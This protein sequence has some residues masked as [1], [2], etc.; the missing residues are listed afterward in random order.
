MFLALLALVWVGWCTLRIPS[1]K[2]PAT[3]IGLFMASVVM[4]LI[5]VFQ[6]ICSIAK[7]AFLCDY[8]IYEPLLL[9]WWSLYPGVALALVIVTLSVWCAHKMS[10]SE[11]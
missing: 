2:V 7:K 4:T 1:D 8:S 6:S 5:N 3:A 9:P 11:E 10:K